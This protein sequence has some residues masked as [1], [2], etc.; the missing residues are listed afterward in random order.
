[1]HLFPNTPNTS[2]IAAEARRIRVQGSEAELRAQFGIKGEAPIILFA[3]RL[4]DAKRP[5]DALAAFDRISEAR[6]AA[7]LVIVGDGPLMPGMKAG[8]RNRDVV[9]TGWMRDPMQLAGLM[10]IARMLILPSAHEPWGAVVNEALAAGTPVIA[11]DRVTSAVELIEAGVNGYVFPVGDVEALSSRIR[12]IL[13]RDVA[14]QTRISDAAQMT[15]ARFGHEF[16]ADNL[17][18]GAREA[19]L[20][21]RDKAK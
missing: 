3:G 8:A 15:A 20:R 1:M 21:Q 4:I 9:F 10:A 6:V 2:T 17:I 5:M 12:D 7:T 13:V 19:L 18:E 11:S 16:A 14:A